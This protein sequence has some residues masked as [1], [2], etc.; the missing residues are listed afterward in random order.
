MLVFFV[1]LSN[2][3]FSERNISFSLDAHL[4]APQFILVLIS[5]DKRRSDLTLACNY[6][7]IAT[8]SIEK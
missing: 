8:S 1:V 6:D 5:M 2:K 7:H 4:F 3:S